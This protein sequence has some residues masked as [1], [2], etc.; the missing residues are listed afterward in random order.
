MNRGITLLEAALKYHELGLS[1]I[2]LK[3]D[4]HPFI[5]WKPHQ[6]ER[7][8]EKQIREWWSKWPSACIGIVTGKIS[9]LTVVDVDSEAGKAALDEFLSYSLIVPLVETPDGYGHFYFKYTD[10]VPTR[11][12]GTLTDCDTRGDF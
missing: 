4:K 11:A 3:L 10:G 1:V 2:P 8:G 5:E 7:A 9:G 6:T 12:R